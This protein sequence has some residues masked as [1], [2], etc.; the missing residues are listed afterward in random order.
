MVSARCSQASAG[1]SWGSSGRGS[2]PC[3]GRSRRTRFGVRCSPNTGRMLSATRMCVMSTQLSLLPLTSC[4]EDS[5]A[6]TFRPQ[7][8]AKG[9]LAASRACGISSLGSYPPSSRGPAG[10]SSRT[11]GVRLPDGWTPWLANWDTS[12]MSAYRCRCRR[13]AAALPMRGAAS[14]CLP[15]LTRSAYGTSNNGCPGDGRD[16]Y[17]TKGKPSLHTMVRRLHEDLEQG[18]LDSSRPQ[19]GPTLLKSDATRGYLE[20]A[21]ELRST[22]S[23]GPRM[24]ELFRGALSPTWCEQYMGFPIGW[25]E[26]PLSATASSPIAPRSSV[27][28]C[29]SSSKDRDDG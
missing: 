23:R 15:T 29:A 20:R 22:R 24:A 5:R 7:E 6:K 17:A 13:G 10:P 19:Y 21:M 8:L 2:G 12:A 4:A 16:E 25:T 3:D 1:S 26:L 9:L 18:V 28:S 11:S 27:T 14:F